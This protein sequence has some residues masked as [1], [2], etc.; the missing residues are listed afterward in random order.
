MGKAAGRHGN[1]TLLD[2]RTQAPGPDYKIAVKL[3]D[4]PPSNLT[5]LSPSPHKRRRRVKTRTTRLENGTHPGAMAA[6]QLIGSRRVKEQEQGLEVVH[7]HTHA[8]IEMNQSVL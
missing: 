6:L 1:P 5:P 8:Q 3:L 4:V 7:T 2:L